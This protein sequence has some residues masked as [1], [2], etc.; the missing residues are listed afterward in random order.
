MRRLG[1]PVDALYVTVLVV[2]GIATA[3]AD[4]RNRKVSVVTHI[5]PPEPTSQ[6]IPDMRK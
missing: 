3:A 5:Q 4:L 2:L 6:D 1:F